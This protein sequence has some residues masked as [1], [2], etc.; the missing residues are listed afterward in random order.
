MSEA[1]RVVDQDE[2]PLSARLPA[3]HDPLADGILMAHQVEWIEDKSFLKFCEKGRRTGITYAEALDD[4]ITAAT[5]REGGGDDVYYIG[6]TKEKGLEFIGYVAHFAHIVSKELATIEEFI[7]EDKQP[8]GTSKGIT[9]YRV[10]FASGFSVTALASKPVAIRGLQGIVV[11]DEAAFHKDV[12]GVIDACNALL[13][14]G[15]KIRIISTHNGED[16]PF[17]LLLKDIEQG[18]YDYSVHRISFQDAIDNGIFER[19]CLIRGWE[20][21]AENKAAWFDRVIKSYGN[22][23]ETRDEELYVVPRRSSGLYFPR[24]LVRRCQ[25][26]GIPVIRFTR[27]AEW[28]LDDGRMAEAADWFADV[29]RPVFAQMETGKRTVFGQDFG[30]DGD[31]SVIWVLQ[32]EGGGVWRTVFVLEM[33]RIPFDVQEWVLFEIIRALPLF[34]HG[35]LDARGNGQSHA[36]KAQQEFGLNKIDCVKA[37][38]EWY[39]QFFPEYRAAYE[40]RSIIVPA[41]EDIVADHRQVIL[42]NGR[43]TMDDKR[44]RGSDGEPRHG[45]TAIAGLLAWAAT[46]EEGEPPAGESIDRDPEASRPSTMP[47]R[48]RAR[49]FTRRAA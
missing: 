4:T 21:T 44:E 39:A 22:D 18:I 8:D 9:A 1:A 42:K 23:N 15:G 28:Y 30:R 24:S 33:R 45:D 14:W 31:L 12:K 25:E 11:I 13:I 17:N 40:D 3:N 48:P 36:E 26:E 37:T 46:I 49:M 5:T 6:D 32:D 38:V 29:M 27:S 19:V 43:P 20:P 7:F 35:K 16:S 47:N 41:V 10:R 34:Y 2:L